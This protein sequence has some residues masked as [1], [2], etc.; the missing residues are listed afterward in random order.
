MTDSLIRQK[1]LVVRSGW[2]IES[3]SDQISSLKLGHRVQYETTND[4]EKGVVEK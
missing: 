4:T 2:E 1:V 3:E